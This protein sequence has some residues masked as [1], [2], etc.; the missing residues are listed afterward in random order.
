[1]SNREANVGQQGASS[2]SQ[3]AVASLIRPD[4]IRN[5]PGLSD[6]QKEQYANAC[7]S[8]WDGLEKEQVD[9]PGYHAAFRKLV[10][11]T[12][13]FRNR[14]KNWQLQQHQQQQPATANGR[15]DRR[16]ELQTRQ[17]MLQNQAS[18]APQV[19]GDG[20]SQPAQQ[21]QQQQQQ[22]Q[23]PAAIVTHIQS[24]PFTAPL[25]HPPGSADAERWIADAKHRYGL[26]LHKV[27]ITKQK[28]H[29]LQTGVQ[30]HI[31][32]GKA[33]SPEEQANVQQ[34]KQVLVRAHAEAKDQIE[35]FRK[36]QYDLRQQIVNQQMSS[37][38][39]AGATALGHST[40]SA[41]VAG[42]QSQL[43][44]QPI[45][46]TM[47]QSPHPPPQGRAG[48]GSADLK[49]VNIDGHTYR[50]G[51]NDQASANPSITTT[52]AAA[53]AAAA[54]VPTSAAPMAGNVNRPVSGTPTQPSPAPATYHQNPGRTSSV[55][56]VGS[57]GGAANYQ[58]HLQPAV[59]SQMKSPQSA[60]PPSAT[61]ADR[62]HPLSQQA[63]LRQAA[64][65]HSN[66][67]SGG[68][69]TVAGLPA[70]TYTPAHAPAQGLTIAST[71][72]DINI[73]KMPI[74]KN[75]TVP[76]PQP[77]NVGQPR[78]TL[79]GGAD[80]G[81]NSTMGQPSLAKLPGY[82]LEGD[83]NRVLSKEKLD[84]LVREVTNNGEGLGEPII[85]PESEEVYSFHFSLFLLRRPPPP[86]S[87][88]F[89][90]LYLSQA[91]SNDPFMIIFTQGL[92]IVLM[93]MGPV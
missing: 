13:T 85:S 92:L 59:G 37:S 53:A 14:V 26:A 86:P 9:S 35:N 71:N 25:V 58:A 56:A 77:A 76:I 69:R 24:F 3:P 82:T 19:P 20:S 17:P 72:P 80:V 89:A 51:A 49:P 12:T 74:P 52:A 5:L 54:V 44:P 32:S 40:E 4:Q 93:C 57:Q 45:P 64:N 18:Q 50:Y 79:T 33:L 15:Q 68:A 34:R 38:I 21:Q 30:Q 73:H 48:A 60:R 29:N 78:P 83:G 31:S 22:P 87:P 28:L 61:P 67:H 90:L 63:A 36:H 84:E 46:M 1:M 10:D 81:S 27:D 41:D 55:D 43:P 7:Q 23:L 42:N 62:P 91:S 75:L 70:L 88:P 66:G 16:A 2:S 8:L 6:A 11:V 39:P 47:G 65:H